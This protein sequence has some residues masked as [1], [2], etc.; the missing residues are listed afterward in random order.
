MSPINVNIE[1]LNTLLEIY[2]NKGYN[3]HLS[4][5]GHIQQS[6]QTHVHTQYDFYFM[7]RINYH[8]HQPHEERRRFRLFKVD[9]TENA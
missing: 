4:V 5:D 6:W 7:E 2:N 1:D 9:N 3:C 8:H